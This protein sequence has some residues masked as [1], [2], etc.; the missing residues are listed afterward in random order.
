[1]WVM[2]ERGFFSA[3]QDREVPTRLLIRARC[4]EDIRNLKDLL[5]DS[6]PWR[7]E[8]SD[9]EWRLSCTV[10]E[11]AGA[12]AN[13][14]LDIDYPNFKSAIKERQG[15]RRADIYMRVWS[16]LLSLEPRVAQYR[17]RTLLNPRRSRKRSG[18]AKVHLQV[19]GGA[20][21]EPV[22]VLCGR[23][24]GEDGWP[25]VQRRDPNDATCGHCLNAMAREETRE[26]GEDLRGEQ[27]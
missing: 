15:K 21:G 25:T 18:G 2:T 5:P 11:W 1:M 8:R 27:V 19:G 12:L 13:M 7:L 9:Y 6:E 10:A 22:R 17:Q 26:L 16:A 20:V 14:A 4:E 3:V 24:R 23:T